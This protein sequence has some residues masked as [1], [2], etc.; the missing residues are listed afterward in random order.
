MFDSEDIEST[1][2]AGY[3]TKRS[4]SYEINP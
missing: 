2:S 3:L 4:A 1:P